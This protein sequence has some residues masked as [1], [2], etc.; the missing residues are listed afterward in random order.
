MTFNDGGDFL[1]LV[2]SESKCT[3]FPVCLIHS[4][5]HELCCC[6]WPFPFP[7]RL[8]LSCIRWCVSESSSFTLNNIRNQDFTT[9]I[10]IHLSGFQL[11]DALVRNILHSQKKDSGIRLLGLWEGK[12]GDASR[13][14]L[15]SSDGSTSWGRSVRGWKSTF[16]QTRSGLKLNNRWW[17][18]TISNEKMIK[19]L[20]WGQR[21]DSWIRKESQLFLTCLPCGSL[22]DVCK[23]SCPSLILSFLDKLL[24]FLPSPG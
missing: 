12:R 16:T 8:S 18:I 6:C 11:L 7:L 3:F 2:L 24:V 4:R 15:G 14:S 23:L 17:L 13:G 10:A 21:R 5:L 9:L 22:R 1:S 20:H 19:V